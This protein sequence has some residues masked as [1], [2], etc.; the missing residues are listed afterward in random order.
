MNVGMKRDAQ[1]RTLEPLPVNPNLIAAVRMNQSNGAANRVGDHLSRGIA[2]RIQRE[3]HDVLANS[4]PAP[5]TLIA[6]KLAHSL[7]PP[8][9]E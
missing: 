6:R 8:C 4:R 2:E 3:H 9:P 5:S 1:K 7:L